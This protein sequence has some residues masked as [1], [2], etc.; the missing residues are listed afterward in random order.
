MYVCCFQA[1]HLSFLYFLMLKVSSH[2]IVFYLILYE[3]YLQWTA[4]KQSADYSHV[5]DKYRNK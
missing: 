4:T 1:D 5:Y 3:F 2:L